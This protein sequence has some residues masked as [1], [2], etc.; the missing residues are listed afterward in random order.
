MMHFLKLFKLGKQWKSKMNKDKVQTEVK[1]LK[2]LQSISEK[3]SDLISNR[4]YES[5]ISLEKQR[6]DILKSFNVKPSDSGIK[7]LQN[8]LEKT[9]KD[10]DII[11][12]EK[13]KINKNFEKAKN[14]FLAY[15]R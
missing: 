12:N 15:G 9:K 3:I 13:L 5:I 11:E 6:L 8:I 1:Q 10:I 2:E 14:I 7:L 4:K